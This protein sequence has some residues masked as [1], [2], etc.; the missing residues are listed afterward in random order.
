M[1]NVTYTARRLR[2]DKVS[3]DRPGSDFHVQEIHAN[4]SV[5]AD[6]SLPALHFE[7][8]AF[9]VPQAKATVQVTWK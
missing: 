3:K 1:D 6:S 9:V 5:V 2:V 7:R 4:T 8:G